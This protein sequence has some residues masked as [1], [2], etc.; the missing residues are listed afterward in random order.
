MNAS[1]SLTGAL[2]NGNQQLATK[3]QLTSSIAG[4][5][6]DLQ[7]ISGFNFQNLEVSTLKV[8]NWIS[9]PQMYVSSLYA[10]NIDLSGI[11]LD[12]SGVF[13]VTDLSGTL[14]QF[15]LTLLSSLQFKFDPTVNL[16][17]NVGDATTSFFIG[18]GT[19][20][21][22]TFLGLGVGAGKAFEGIGNGI[23]A[24]IM[25]NGSQ[26]TYI[27]STQFELIG[28]STQLQVST[29]G[30]AYPA[31]SSIMRY[32]SSSGAPNEVPGEPIFTSTI[33]YPGQICIR[34][35]SDPFP[36]VSQYSNLIGST[37]Q[38]FG[39]WIPLEGLEPENIV[40]NSIST[41]FISAAQ[42]YSE[43]GQIVSLDSYQIGTSNLG[44]GTGANFNYNAG[45]TFDLGSS[46]DAAIVGSINQWNFLTN[47]PMNF[48]GQ[49]GEPGALSPSAVLTLGGG[50]QSYLQISSINATGNVQANSG[51]ISSLVVND[52]VV[53]S[54]FSTV[55]TV[56]A[57]NIFSTNIVTANL[58]STQNLQSKYISPFSFSSILGNPY[59]SFDINKYDSI[60]STT[61]NSVSSLTQNI[62]NYTLVEQIQ[63]QTSFNLNIAE[64]PFGVNYNL[65]P[66]NATQW[67]SSI[68]IFNDYQNA[69]VVLLPQNSTF[70]K[71]L[72][73]G[74]FDI[75]TQ[76]NP[77]TPGYYAPFAVQQVLNPGA[78]Y[79]NLSTFLQLS[80]PNPPVSPPVGTWRFTIGCNGFINSVQANPTPFITT[81]SNVFTISQD[82]NDT[83]L[84]AS[85]RLN[86]KAGEIV[87][88]GTLNLTNTNVLNSYAINSFTSNA[89]VSTL[90]GNTSFFSSIVTDPL[91]S[92]GG[93]QSFYS[94]S[95]ISYNSNPVTVQPLNF[96]F[97]NNS[98]DFGPQYTL[99]P[100]FMGNNYFTSYNFTSWSNTIWNN[101][102]AS[103]F[104]P[105]IFCGD[106]QAPIGTYSA[107]FYI[108]NAGA[109]YAL[110]VYTIT[111]AGSNLLG[112]IAGGT[113]AR[114]NTPD[115]INWTL[116]SVTNPSGLGGTYSN[117]LTLQ[118]NTQYTQVTDNQN[119]Q[120]QAPN[121]TLTTGTFGLF[122]DQIRVNSHKY[123]TAA[124]TGLPSYPIGIENTVYQD[125]NIAW[126][127]TIS[128]F[129]Q[130][131][132][133]NVV[134]NVTGA[135]YYDFNSWIIQVI[136]SRFRTNECTI[137]SWDVQPTVIAVSG[138]TGYCWG[139]NR[140]IQVSGNPGSGAN[141][142]NWIIAFPRNYCTFT[143]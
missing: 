47:Q 143:S 59:G 101:T 75:Q 95:N 18:L 112:N 27:N 141:N 77:A 107:Y 116:T 36:V 2:W 46:G 39:Q 134:Y 78:E 62:L 56:N 48:F 54:T 123:G 5:Y 34:S 122:A 10:G 99:I 132:A 7:D 121:T 33:F 51:F 83:T 53:L 65:T 61:F 88:N 120:I 37:I 70:M 55:F 64:T 80:A 15:N 73:T 124:A 11:T 19:L 109:G 26:N 43:F 87:M 25:A 49:L 139:F 40:A 127:Y 94:K 137:V 4:L 103:T 138:G 20:L 76:Y 24:M 17:L 93:F 58:V 104:T 90:Q 115:G 114:I 31:Y 30:N 105:K 142:W 22:E 136:P 92:A 118:Q 140:F 6:T 85:D 3:Y 67:G 44:I 57:F 89:T 117:V 128:G 96:T 125:N 66:Q 133:T 41:N 35:I 129:W 1:P 74:V 106:I 102:S 108:N 23:A 72:T 135:V 130:S 38:Q 21:F 8:H 45:A 60:V 69:G 29:L 9:A 71:A 91:T 52:L 111:S 86:L 12:S 81:N 98:P 79:N 126:T 16:E 113:Y 63:D 131:D 68:M 119:L 84:Y 13:I 82:I 14:S 50:G 100:N 42:L 110:P 97:I 32:V 28:G